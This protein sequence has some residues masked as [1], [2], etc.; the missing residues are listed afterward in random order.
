VTN[1]PTDVRDHSDMIAELISLLAGGA[2]VGA[3]VLAPPF[4]LFRALTRQRRSHLSGV[5]RHPG[6]PRR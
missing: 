3:A 1:E 5:L 2:A 6:D 4:L